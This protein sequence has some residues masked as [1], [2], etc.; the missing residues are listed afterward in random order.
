MPAG[1]VSQSSRL[2]LPAS[3]DSPGRVAASPHRLPSSG[4][5]KKGFSCQLNP[6]KIA[7]SVTID[8][9]P[10]SSPGSRLVFHRSARMEPWFPDHRLH[11]R[12][13]TSDVVLCSHRNCR[14]AASCELFCIRGSVPVRSQSPSL[15]K[16]LVL[17]SRTRI[18]CHNPCIR[19]IC[20][21][22]CVHLP[23]EVLLD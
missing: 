15:R 5:A 17:K 3:L 9:W 12:W 1:E 19:Y 4:H 2:S 18:H 13:R 11:K 8:V 20:P 14:C 23:S 6:L 16:I 10:G 21:V 22:T 7:Y